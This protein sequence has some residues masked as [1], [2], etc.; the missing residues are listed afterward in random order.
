[1]E[2]LPGT[3]LHFPLYTFTN[4]KPLTSFINIWQQSRRIVNVLL[5]NGKEVG[6][7]GGLELEKVRMTKQLTELSVVGVC[8]SL[9]V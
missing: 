5:L 4:E 6:V 1:M 2:T 7:P 9:V 8:F 3:E